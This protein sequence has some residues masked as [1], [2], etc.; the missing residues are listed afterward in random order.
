MLK[1]KQSC[2][3]SDCTAKEMLLAKQTSSRS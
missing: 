1:Q 3:N 2:L